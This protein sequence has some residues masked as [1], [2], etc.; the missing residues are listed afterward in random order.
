LHVL[1]LIP[2]W[3]EKARAYLAHYKEQQ[4]GAT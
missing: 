3:P 1:E 4:N 2:D